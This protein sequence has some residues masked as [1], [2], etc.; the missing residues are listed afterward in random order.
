[1]PKIIAVVCA[2][3]LSYVVFSSN[4]FATNLSDLYDWGDWY[5]KGPS[6]VLGEATSSASL[7]TPSASNI[8]DLTAPQA[9]IATPKGSLPGDLLY[10]FKPLRENLN[11][12][13]TLDPKSKDE[14]R[15]YLAEERLGETIA[16]IEKKKYAEAKDNFKKYQNILKTISSDL[17]NLKKRD[18]K[19][20]DLAMN[21]ELVSAK[22]SLILEKMSAVAPKEVDFPIE[23]TL[24]ITAS[25]MDKVSDI[26]Q[27]DPLP[28]ELKDRLDSLKNLGILR[29]SEVAAIFV[30]K[31][32]SDVRSELK[33]LA[34]QNLFPKSDIKKLD[35]SQ[36]AY[37][38]A[39]YLRVTE[40][41]K[42]DELKNLED[43][44]PDEQTLRRIEEF[45]QKYIPGE[46]IPPDLRK[47]WVPLQ[48][49]EELQSTIRVD[50]V[51][52]SISPKNEEDYSQIQIVLEKLKPSKEQISAVE[53]WT[54]DNPD[55]IPPPEIQRIASLA[56]N[57]G[58]DSGWVPSESLKKN[59]NTGFPIEYQTPPGFQSVGSCK[60]TKDCNDLCQKNPFACSAK[61]EGKQIAQ[62]INNDGTL[63]LERSTPAKQTTTDQS[64]PNTS[65]GGNAFEN[66][67]FGPSQNQNKAD[68][69]PNSENQSPAPN[70]QANS[71]Q[72]NSSNQPSTTT[73]PK[74]VSNTT[75]VLEQS[76]SGV[77]LPQQQGK[78]SSNETTNT[79]DQSGAITQQETYVSPKETQ[80]ETTPVSQPEQKA[81]TPKSNSNQ[82]GSNPNSVVSGA[83]KS[84]C[85]Q[86][87]TR[88]RNSLTGEIKNF[89]N[90]CLPSGWYPYLGNEGKKSPF[91]AFQPYRR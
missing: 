44:K 29:D 70:T 47:W 30:L 49:V 74:N 17:D 90:S 61:E 27:R 77:I 68:K 54:K 7:A 11:L 89:T 6:S 8:L 39:D 66:P 10:F 84:Y 80:Q 51:R 88:A 48:R 31:F 45:T 78:G 81:E 63:K 2:L 46:P 83:P 91:R 32:R 55:K 67:S 19:F 26:L 50:L 56:L 16:L 38:P 82:S 57:L 87:Q 24:S 53:K 43:L 42:L 76:E 5:Y 9:N 58:T 20:E 69:E 28:A 75:S 37:Y 71:G 52:N 36:L 73:S 62:N 72:N 60:N 18:L 86:T 79:N 13:F 25:S 34:D 35:E 22:H 64:S 21:V 15:L 23:Q 65:V 33:N 1:M 14:K 3:V 41:K 12:L 59:V 40:L 4:T 85:L